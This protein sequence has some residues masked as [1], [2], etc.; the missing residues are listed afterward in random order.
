MKT[1]ESR[2]LL[3]Y[4][5]VPAEPR[6]I[7][8][9]STIAQL[10][11]RFN[12][13]LFEPH[14]TIYATR[15][16]QEDPAEVL[17]AALAGRGSFPLLVRDVQC[18]DEFTKTVFV[19]FEQSPELSRLKCALQEASAGHDE[20]ELNPHLSLI[21]NEM[22]PDDKIAIATSIHLPFTEILFD[23]AKA[24]ISPTPVR[25]REDVE[26]WRVVATQKLT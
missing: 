12:A 7:F 4:W 23:C 21:Y 15:K 6:R 11:V 10:A 18:S 19:R 3:A 24:I 9:A 14:V 16:G 13:P 1:N 26:A 22:S 5:L 2:A 8:F 25:S 20:Y 17:S